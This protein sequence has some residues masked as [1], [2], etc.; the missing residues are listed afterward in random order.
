MTAYFIKVI[1]SA[2]IIVIVSEISRFN[3]T[4]GGLIKALPLISILSIIWVYIDSRDVKVISQLSLS[5]FWYVLPTLPM[6]L[7]LP[8]LLKYKINFYISLCIAMI[9]MIIGF[10]I[11]SMILKKW[12]YYL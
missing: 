1:I 4:I 3:V 5:T 6:F 11:I 7:I 12:G 8:L 2:I 9:I 10:I